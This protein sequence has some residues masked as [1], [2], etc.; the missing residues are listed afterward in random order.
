MVLCGCGLLG[1]QTFAR[2]RGIKSFFALQGSRCRTSPGFC[3]NGLYNGLTRQASSGVFNFNNRSLKGTVAKN[4]SP[5]K[6][7]TPVHFLIAPLVC[8]YAKQLL[9]HR[10]VNAKA[11]LI[12]AVH[13]KPCLLG[14]V[15][16]LND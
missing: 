14:D 6:T 2:R 9:P 15:M 3:D 11:L 10:T 7:S 1:R 16:F 12:P 5:L 8:V 13:I 4:I